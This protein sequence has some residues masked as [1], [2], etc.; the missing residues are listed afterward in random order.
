MRVKRIIMENL[1]NSQHRVDIDVLVNDVFLDMQHIDKRIELCQIF[2]AVKQLH[3]N[4]DLFIFRDGAVA[5]T[6][7]G[8]VSYD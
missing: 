7:K 6:K 1:P 5:A 2:K 8:L 3:E 4:Q